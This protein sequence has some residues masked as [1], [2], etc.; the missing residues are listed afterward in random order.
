MLEFI[1]AV[2]A[3][4]GMVAPVVKNL[5]EI[6][7]G[8]RQMLDFADHILARFAK[9][10]SNG[11][12]QAELR[13]ALAQVAAMPQVE[14]DKKAEEIIDVE[15]ADKPPEYR[16]AVTEYVKLIPPRLRA[17]FSRPEDPSGT[18]VPAKWSAT[19]G[20]DILPFLPPRP[21]M[22]SEGDSPPEASRWILTERLGIGGFG[23][24]WKARS[25]TMQNSYSAF[26]FCLDPV[27]QQRIFENELEN[28]ELV[29]NEL[30]DHPN[31]VKLIDA[32]LE[33]DA[34]WLQYEYIPGGDLGQLAGTWPNELAVRAAL[35][36]KTIGILADTLGHCHNE[37]P[38]KVIHR[39][40]KPANVLVGKNGTLK[41]TDF[42]IS[43]TQARQALEEAR[44]AT[45][46]GA[47]YTTPS[48]VRWANTPMYASP[49]QR[50]GEDSHTSD[51]VH[52]LGVMLYQMLLG[53][54]NLELGVDM[55]QDLE[56]QY[57][58]AELLDLLSRSVA[59]R[60]DRRFQNASEL[61]EALARLPKKLIVEPV[62]ISVA[63]QEAQLY[64][65]IDRRV[66]DARAKNETA[67]QQ[68]DRREWKAAVAT[69]EAIFHPVMRDEDLYT[70]AVQHRD[71]KRFLNGLG[72]EFALVP[73]GTF[74]M[75][76][77]DGNCGDKQVTIDR[78]FY[79][80]VCPVTQEEWQKVMGSNPS[81]FRKGGGG[82]DKLSGVSDAD[83][84]RYPVESVSWNDCQVFIKK[85]NESLKETGWMYRLPREAEW[86]YACRG[87][88]ITQALCGWNFYLRS[89][90]T[91][92]SAQ[93]ANLSISAL[94]RTC[95]VGLYEANSLGL[96][97][98]HGNVWEWCEDA[99]DGATRVRRGGCW[100]NA[101]EYCRAATR[102][103]HAPI[104]LDIGLGLRLA[105]VPSGK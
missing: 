95:K 94:N 88:A 42:G 64:D 86:E 78:D 5:G 35:A 77:Q 12:Q 66:D 71:G 8:G 69:L 98:M 19:R 25:K 31:I 104:D 43:D 57:V 27:S 58:C 68:L 72:M 101:A 85:L 1:A 100:A 84:R 73:A 53:N 83:L 4:I 45:A 91:T 81:H 14:F 28:I 67:R 44:I 2:A 92:L 82:A 7:K 37:L 60:I 61:A 65:E 49:Q 55:W 3:A 22:F 38:R 9:K 40:M 80:G 16:K 96:F 21:P 62:V 48:L 99:Y 13:V 89:P 20:E 41:I 70:R 32:Y 47:S 63:D 24:V 15:L 17:T 33:S 34:P 74:W 30:I 26:K 11:Q 23:E 56:E 39:D 50:K 52:A 105:R 29:K 97:D 59:A 75:G 54:L 76:G 87:A 46:S 79:I 90:T 36:V 6:A 10:G 18:T 93:Q 102:F 103:G 51:D